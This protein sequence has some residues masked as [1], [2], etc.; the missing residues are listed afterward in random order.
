MVI[1]V[2]QDGGGSFLL[3]VLLQVSLVIVGHPT[4][5]ALLMTCSGPGLFCLPVYAIISRECQMAFSRRKTNG[6]ATSWQACGSRVSGSFYH[7]PK[8]QLTSTSTAK[9]NWQEAKATLK[10]LR[11]WLHY[12]TY[13]CI[14]VGVSSLSL[15]SPTIVAGLG[16]EN[17]QAQL[18]TVPPYAIAYV[19]CLVV[20]YISDRT[21]QRGLVAGTC[22]AIG[23]VSFIVQGKH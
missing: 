16:Y 19:V 9:L 11:L 23:S 12:L 20:A 21:K 15:F 18:F 8:F 14:G 2:S 22:F 13:L 17:L 5:S 4:V 7:N 3:K 6:N 10:S 1:L